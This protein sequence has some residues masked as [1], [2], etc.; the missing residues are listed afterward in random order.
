MI[1]AQA[2]DAG[3]GSALWFYLFT[4]MVAVAIVTTGVLALR[5]SLRRGDFPTEIEKFDRNAMTIFDEEEPAG[6][7]TDFFPGKNPRLMKPAAKTGAE[8]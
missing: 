2:S 6:R 3:E 7:Q 1:L 5:W 8:A 4:G